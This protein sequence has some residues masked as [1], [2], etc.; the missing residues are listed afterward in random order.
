M[1]TLETSAVMVLL[2]FYASEEHKEHPM[3]ACTYLSTEGLFISASS[4]STAS[5]LSAASEHNVRALEQNKSL[6]MYVESMSDE[7]LEQTLMKLNLLQGEENIN[8]KCK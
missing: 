6:N 2:P 4:T 5:T 1:N 7:E 3:A 8:N